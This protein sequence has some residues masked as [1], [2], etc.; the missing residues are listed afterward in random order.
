MAL[1]EPKYTDDTFEVKGL[2]FIVDKDFIKEA[3][4]IEI[5]FTGMGFSI[6]SSMDFNSGDGGCGGC[7]SGSC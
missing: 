4:T 2:T 7:G 6:N 3:K 1:D 5:D